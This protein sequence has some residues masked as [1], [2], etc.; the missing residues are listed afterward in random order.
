[1]NVVHEHNGSL[2]EFFK[3]W[4]VLSDAECRVLS[5]NEVEDNVGRSIRSSHLALTRSAL[6]L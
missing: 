1:M 6:E 5:I 3:M 4:G 2:I